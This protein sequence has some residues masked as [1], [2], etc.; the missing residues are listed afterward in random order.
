VEELSGGTATPGVRWRD[1]KVT[2]T[3][4][5]EVVAQLLEMTQPWWADR[6]V[7]ADIQLG[8][9]PPLT[10]APHRLLGPLVNVV[11][12]LAGRLGAG[13]RLRLATWHSDSGVHILVSTDTVGSPGQSP[14]PE[15]EQRAV[16]SRLAMARAALGRID[17]RL[18]YSEAEGSLEVV[19][20][21]SSDGRSPGAKVA[22]RSALR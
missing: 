17:G 13:D 7:G 15:P 6:G 19:V 4:I 21:T 14:S 18:C 8:N 3:S 12:A 2:A 20:P 16:R 10:V 5:P 1:S 11:V 9:G 22:Q